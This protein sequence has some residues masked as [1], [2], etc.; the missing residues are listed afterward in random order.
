MVAVF[1][2]QVAPK[3]PPTISA[4]SLLL[5]DRSQGQL[6][7]YNSNRRV[8]FAMVIVTLAAWPLVAQKN[9]PLMGVGGGGG[10]V[11]YSIGNTVSAVAAGSGATKTTG[12]ITITAGQ[13]VAIGVFGCGNSG[14]SAT[15]PTSFTVSDT[16]GDSPTCV[17]GTF[18]S[19]VSAGQAEELCYV[20]S[21]AGGTGTFTVTIV[22]AGTP[23]FA[24]IGVAAVNG[25]KT[26]ACADTSSANSHGTN[27]AT[28]N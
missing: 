17:A 22:G 8:A 5:P 28:T 19:I 1:T 11:S 7:M 21:S 12:N 15:P 25:I 20:C 24:G 26:S 23:F 27:D 4:T 6:P 9:L 10:S 14:C 2:L 18:G 13:A 3:Q 16:L